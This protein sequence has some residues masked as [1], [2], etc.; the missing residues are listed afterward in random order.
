MTAEKLR[1]IIVASVAS[2]VVLL[3]VLLTVLV[4]QMICLMQKNKTLN[5]LKEAEQKYEDSNADKEDEIAAWLEDWKI[6]EA[7]WELGYRVDEK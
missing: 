7:A 2:A 4:F 3:V 1:K 5:A 6:M